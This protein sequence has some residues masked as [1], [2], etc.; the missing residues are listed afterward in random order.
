MSIHRWQTV[1]GT[2]HVSGRASGQLLASNLELSFWGGVDH[3]TGEVIDHSHPLYRQRL[4]NKILAIPGGRG[5]CSGSATILELIVNGNGPRALIFERT[6]EILAVGVFVAEELFGKTIPMLIVSHKGF[7]SILGWNGKEVHVQS[8]RISTYPLEP[9]VNDTS[10]SPPIDAHLHTPELSEMDKAML[11]GGYKNDSGYS[12]AQAFAMKIII[13]TASIMNAPSLMSISQAHVDGAHF[14]PA[15]VLFGKRLRDLGGN[16]AV[17]TTVNAITI[18]QQRWRDLSVDMSFGTESEEL[19]RAFLEMGAKMSFTC[20]PYQLD[21]APKLGDQVAFGESNVVCYANSVLGAR[22]AKY[23]NMLEALI[24]LT[25]RV[26]RAGIHLPENRLRGTPLGD[27]FWPLLGYEIGTKAASRIPI[28]AGFEYMKPPPSRDALKAF[29]A[30]FATSA[31]APMF[32]MLGVTPEAE[33][34]RALKES[35]TLSP[36]IAITWKDLEA[37]WITFNQNSD[38]QIPV[39]TVDL[40]SLGNPHFSLLELKTLSHLVHGR[41]KSPSTSVIVTTSRAQH[42]LATQ[43]GYIAQ[44]EAFGV[45]VLTDTCW[46]FIRDPVIKKD[47]KCIMTNSGKYAH[48]GPG[49][50]GR[51]FCFG[52]LEE[53]VESACSGRWEGNMPEWIQAGVQNSH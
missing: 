51:E 18:D 42:S 36:G 7:R 39:R 48:Y 22:T 2:P 3:V 35:N 24:A 32:H 12:K 6:N 46:C 20:A 19:A 28:I 49:L 13:R 30:A 23:P 5:S 52:G 10:L 47:V 50:T 1:Y 38:F 45:Q 44:L 27:S 33:Q 26:P 17:S 15:S 37:T 31:G 16:F 25:G 11:Q 9:S 8:H 34:H 53:C 40:I 21:S 14:G 43:A 29:S 4:K 41:I